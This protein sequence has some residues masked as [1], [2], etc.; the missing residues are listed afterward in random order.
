LTQKYFERLGKQVEI[1]K[2]S[3]AAEVTPHLGVADIISDLVS[4]GSTLKMNH[5]KEIA[6]ITNSQAVVIANHESYKHRREEIDE[7]VSA[8][9]SVMDAEN[10]KYL[11]ADVPTVALDEVRKYFPGIAGPTVMNIAG[12][13]D[14]VAVHVVID[15]DQVYDAII[16]L[17][18]LGASGILITPIDRMVP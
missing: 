9:R 17:K 16:R 5:L 1:T 12:R 6:V 3:G 4:S 10:K 13:E 11:M 18:R 2:I 8:M 14:V 7:L 15:K